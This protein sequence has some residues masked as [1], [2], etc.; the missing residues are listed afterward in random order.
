MTGGYVAF[1]YGN[2]TL[3]F[4]NLKIYGGVLNFS[5]TAVQFN[6]LALLNTA[7]LH[8]QSTANCTFYGNVSLLGSSI[9][10][11]STPGSTVTCMENLMITESTLQVDS[12][13]ILRITNS[14]IWQS[15]TITAGDRISGGQFILN[16]TSSTNL[17]NTTNSGISY[18]HFI[19]W[20][21]LSFT[22][23][24]FYL[25]YGAIFTNQDS[26][27]LYINSQD[28]LVT[29]AWYLYGGT[30]S[31]LEN[32]GT[33]RVNISSAFSFECGIT[34]NNY[35]AFYLVSGTN[36]TM[37]SSTSNYA[38]YRGMMYLE[39]LTIFQTIP[40]TSPCYFDGGLLSGLGTV[41][42]A[43]Q[44]SNWTII[45]PGNS[46]NA[47]SLSIR[48]LSMVGQYATIEIGVV[49]GTASNVKI[50]TTAA[51]GGVLKI[52]STTG[53]LVPDG[54]Y[55][56]VIQ[57]YTSSTGSFAY[58]FTTNKTISGAI[59]TSV[60]L[61]VSSG[62]G[63][64][65]GGCVNGDCIGNGICQ[66]YDGWAGTSCEIAFCRIPCRNGALCAN[67][68]NSCDCSNIGFEGSLCQT[69]IVAPCNL[70]TIPNCF[71]NYLN[72]TLPPS[73]PPTRSLCTTSTTTSNP[74]SSLSTSPMPSAK[75]SSGTPSSTAIS[76]IG[77][78]SPIAPGIIALIVLIIG[79][80]GIM[81]GV[82]IIYF[83]RK[84]ARVSCHLHILLF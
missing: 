16:S 59:G 72:T 13:S 50:L 11:I 68:P 36:V 47:G 79:T 56:G 39:D 19:N 78:P 9:M 61:N 10:R 38:Q 60:S 70:T 62:S 67:I 77:N 22:P 66:C 30:S 34:V 54:N 49:F 75:F 32:F 65:C 64:N 17:I 35:G 8:C 84:K 3:S 26:A 80:I 45:S 24:T 81:G 25:G 7:T 2:K 53:G 83:Y 28:N 6:G 20:G 69:P 21:Y 74:S 4:C 63:W 44:A 12:M 1:D 82:I 46:T 51:F 27:M 42:C 31:Y 29:I 57:G 5:N 55:S 15:G 71:G 43:L 14:F 58:Y 52:I 37:M 76:Q 73:L 23:S 40:N 48:S 41:S 18:V 33:I